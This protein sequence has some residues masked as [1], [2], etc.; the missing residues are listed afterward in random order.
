MKTPYAVYDVGSRTIDVASIPTKA[1]IK[2]KFYSDPTYPPDALPPGEEYSV[3]EVEASAEGVTEGASVRGYIVEKK[4]IRELVSK[5]L[6]NEELLYFALENL[7]SEIKRQARRLS[8]YSNPSLPYV[9]VEDKKARSALHALDLKIRS[10]QRT[11]RKGEYPHRL[12][13]LFREKEA[14]IAKSKKKNPVVKMKWP[15]VKDK[16]IRYELQKLEKKILLAKKA[17]MPTSAY[18]RLFEK[19]SALLKEGERRAKLKKE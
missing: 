1:K 17:K 19:Y 13:K 4:K 14:L 3:I 12:Q 15:K 16:D 9:A 6:E 8:K 5:L 10:A 18:K 2:V 11:L 7:K